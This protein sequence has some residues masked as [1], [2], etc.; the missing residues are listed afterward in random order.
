MPD[1]P[2]HNLEYTRRVYDSVLDW[3]KNADAKAQ[4]IFTLDGAFL[5]F[6]TGS[7]FNKD[8]EDVLGRISWVSGCLLAAMVL[9]LATSI[10][11]AIACLWSRIHSES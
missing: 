6:L 4:V 8:L 3:Y 9:C 5:T 1:R 7:I 11:S 2:P 10:I